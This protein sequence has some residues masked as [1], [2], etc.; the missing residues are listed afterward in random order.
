MPVVIPVS[1]NILQMMPMGRLL[2]L[3]LLAFH[4]NFY[5]LAFGKE[6]SIR[7]TLTYWKSWVGLAWVQFTQLFDE[8]A[9]QT[10][11]IVCQSDQIIAAAIWWQQ[12]DPGGNIIVSRWHGC[13]AMLTSRSQEV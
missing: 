12:L 4:L 7:D 6:R 5:G 13:F 11:L 10:G 1:M 2:L 8:Q 9:A 3:T